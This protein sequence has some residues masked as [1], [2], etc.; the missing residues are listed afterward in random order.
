MLD[1][2]G[3]E[4]KCFKNVSFESERPFVNQNS[5]EILMPAITYSREIMKFQ[6]L[7]QH[8]KSTWIYFLSPL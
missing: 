3:Y 6:N 4:K 7:S 2:F 1:C 5:T 8:F